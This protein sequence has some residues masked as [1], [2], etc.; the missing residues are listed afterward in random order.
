MKP[1]GH[2]PNKRKY[3]NGEIN[4]GVEAETKKK[5]TGPQKNQ[6]DDL[7]ILKT[8]T[9]SC[10]NEGICEKSDPTDGKEVMKR[11]YAALMKEVEKKKPNVAVVNSYLNKEYS[12]RRSWLQAMS[13][14]ERVEKLMDVY[15]CFKDHIEIIE[16]ARR[17]LGVESSG[18]REEFKN[19]CIGLLADE[20]EPIIYYGINKG[21]SPPKSP[22]ASKFILAI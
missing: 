20:I 13:A 4:Q 21:I 17:V 22:K 5:K 19:Q 15:P 11:H 18:D 8:T 6:G 14:G 16:E 3:S 12:A 9:D 10:E 2:C 7:E 1:Q